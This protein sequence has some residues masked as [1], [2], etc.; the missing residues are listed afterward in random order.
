MQAVWK[1]WR[2]TTATPSSLAAPIGTYR[3][4]SAPIGA[5]RH[6]RVW[7]I[8][9]GRLETSDGLYPVDAPTERGHDTYAT[10]PRARDQVCLGKVETVQLMD[11]DGT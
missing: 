9:P 3:H 2:R 1:A 5:Y 6:L 11:R 10:L 7:G 4:L 8:R